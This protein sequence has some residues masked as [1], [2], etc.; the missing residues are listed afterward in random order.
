MSTITTLLG[1]G[2]VGT[3]RSTINTNFSNLNTDKAE[4]AGPDFTG[5]VSF[6]TTT[7]FVDSTNNRVG[8]GTITP[9]YDFCV[10]NTGGDAD[11]AITAKDASATSLYMGTASDKTAFQLLFN[12]SDEMYLY[13]DS[14][15]RMMITPA[16]NVAIGENTAGRKLQVDAT[17]YPRRECRNRR[18]HSGP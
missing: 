10:E 7:L 1:A 6:D 11:V 9:G 17:D 3:D 8:V 2:N 4:L 14:T 5:D 12:S 18:K 16:G 13:T 15:Q